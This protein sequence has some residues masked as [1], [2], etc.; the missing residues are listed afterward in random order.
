MCK[1]YL[2]YFLLPLMIPSSCLTWTTQT[3]KIPIAIWLTSHHRI[4]DATVA[5]GC[6]PINAAKRKGLVEG[7]IRI[8]KCCESGVEVTAWG[9]RTIQNGTDYSCNKFIETQNK[10]S[11]MAQSTMTALKPVTSWTKLNAK[12][13]KYAS[14]RSFFPCIFQK[15]PGSPKFPCVT[16]WKL[17]RNKENEQ[18]VTKI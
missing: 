15:M 3:S 16:K 18:T 10:A 13:Q 9:N 14:F 4:P 5:K 17:H 8:W 1:V 12:C 7:T 11:V 2:L 6:A